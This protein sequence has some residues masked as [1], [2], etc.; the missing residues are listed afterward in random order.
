METKSKKIMIVCVAL[1]GFICGITYFFTN[2]HKLDSKE[3]QQ[4]M[5]EKDGSEVDSDDMDKIEEEKKDDAKSD[6]TDENQEQTLAE[7]NHQNSSTTG[8]YRPNTGGNQGTQPKPPVT[9]ENPG[10]S[11]QL[12]NL[13]I[14]NS[15][16]ENGMITLSNKKYNTITIRSDVEEKTKVVFDTVEVLNG[17][18]LEKP[19]NYQLD[20]VNSHLSSMMVTN[21]SVSV[22]S[23]AFRARKADMNKSLDGATV[24]FKNGSTVNSISVSSNVEINGTTPVSNV[25]VNGGNEVV[26]NIPST[27][28]ALNTQGVVA[29]NQT[30]GNLTNHKKDATIVVNAPVTNFKNQAGSTIHVNGGN[31]ISSFHTSG[32]NTIVSGNGTITNTNIS[33]S[34][35]RIYTNVVNQPKVDPEVDQVLIRTESKVSI[36]NAISTAQGSVTFTLSEPVSKLSL[37]DI[38]VICNAGKSI[39][40]FN[41]TTKDNKTYTL[42]TSYYKNDSYAL[43]ITL[44]NGNI[45]STDFDTDYANPTV[46]NVVV[47]RTSDDAATLELYGVDEGGTL[48]YVLEDATTREVVSASSIKENGTSAFVKVGYNMIPITN[49]EPGKSYNLYYVIEGY[50]ENISKVKGPFEVPGQVKQVTQGQYQIVYAKEEIPNRFVFTLD[51]APQREL[52]LSDF[53]IVCPKESNLTTSGAQFIV[54]PDRLTYIIIVPDNYGHGD[55]KYTVK[56]KVSDTE[57]IEGSF[58]SHFNPPVITGAVD[59][60]KRTDENTAEFVFQSDEFGMVYYGVYEWNGAIYDYNSTTPFANDVLT[61]AIASKQQ[62]LNM[63]ENKITIDLTGVS[64]TRNTRLWALFVDQAG[65]YRVGF[66]DH[67]KIPEYVDPDVP[68]D[69][70]TVQITN[71][72]VINNNYFSIDFNDMIGWVSATDADIKLSIV[73]GGTLPA[74]VLYS[75]DNDTP[76]HLGIELKNHVLTTGVYKLTIHTTDKNDQPITIEKQFEIN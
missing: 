42:T 31:T 55:N 64:V 36:V 67:Y 71:F 56:I 1:I 76:K 66:V 54:S 58:V 24:N 45:I 22:F 62:V 23:Y 74:K 51:K 19:K 10:E 46:N 15:M 68:A 63:G 4:S 41:L 17:L 47:E 40:L 26:L 13:V 8:N 43:Y 2:Q 60:V 25:A 12:E 52:T 21:Q 34:N 53:E 44:P 7:S 30:V 3:P 49:L 11:E 57:K 38:S 20:I 72:K 33:A 29:I 65:N 70:G 59:N 16:I 69:P 50:F 27:N 39:T 14:T 32:E 6:F 35:T 37:S 28:V 73:S 5:D 18:V 75:V 48:Y 61:G 9:P